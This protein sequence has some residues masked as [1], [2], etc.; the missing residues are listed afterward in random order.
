MAHTMYMTVRG[1]KQG[2]F[3]GEGTSRAKGKIPLLSFQM[4]VDSLRDAAS[5]QPLGRR[6]YKPI[7]IRKEIGAS[8]P[9]FLQALA[10]NEVLITVEFEFLSSNSDGEEAI[11]YTVEL[12]N[13]TV[14]EVAQSVDT[15]ETGGPLVDTRRLEVVAFTFQKIVVSDTPGETSFSDDWMAAT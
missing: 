11:D 4:E 2:T 9:Q 8:S 5:G 15:A 10:T 6:Q 1:A 12:T 3:K 13:A 14:S 7:T